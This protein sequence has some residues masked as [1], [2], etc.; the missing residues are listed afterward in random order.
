MT[1][2]IMDI[3]GIGPEFGKKLEM[4]NVHTT[5]DLLKHFNDPT[6]RRNLIEKTGASEPVLT[7]WVQMAELMRIK[8]VGPQYAELLLLAGVDTVDK[9]RAVSPETFEK[10][11]VELNTQHKVTGATPKATDIQQ[12]LDEAKTFE[13]VLVR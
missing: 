7:K 10:K 11:L 6:M 12:W 13:P 8:G 5:D 9:L 1:Y 4:V 3:Q 2:K